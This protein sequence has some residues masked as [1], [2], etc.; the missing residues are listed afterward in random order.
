MGAK[1]RVSADIGG[2]F[3]DLVLQNAETG[4]TSTGKML[5]TREN[6]AR[7]VLDGLRTFL[8]E[9]AAARFLIHGTTVG[10]NAVLERRGAR[11][12][13]VTTRGFRDVYAIAGNDRRDIFSIHYRKPRPLI[14]RGDVF[15]VRERLNA[16]GSAAIP[17]V[18]EDLD[19]VAAAV[20]AGRY[21][22]VAVCLLFAYLNPVHELAVERWLRERLPDVPITLSHRVSP[23]WREYART[24]TAVMNAY[25]APVVQRYLATLMEKVRADLGISRLHVMESNGGAMTAEA[26]REKPIQSLLSGAGRRHDRGARGE[27][28]DRTGESHL[29]RHGRDLVRREP[30]HRRRP[31]P[32]PRRRRSSLP[33]QMSIVD[34]HVIGA[35]GGSVAWLEG[36]HLRV[37]PRSAGS[38]PGPA[39]YGA[40]GAEPTVTDANLVLG[41][42]DP[43]RFAGGRIRLDARAARAA[44]ASI[45]RAL[46]LGTEEMAAGIVEIVNAKMADA[47]R[48]IT[49]RRGIDP[50]DFALFA[51]GGAGPMQAAALAEQ[52]DIGEV[53]VPVHPGTFSAWGM[54]QADVRHDLKQTWFA[55]WDEVD[56][57]EV[58]RAFQALEAEGRAW[59]ER[60]EVPD[61][62]MAFVRSADLRYRLQEYQLTCPLPAGPGRLDREAVR[63]L[64]DA[65]YQRQYG[66]G[67]RRRGWRSSTC[68][69]PRPASSTGRPS[70][71]RRWTAAGR[72]GRA[73]SSSAVGRYARPFS[74]ASASRPASPWPGPP[75][76]KSRPRPPSCLPAGGPGC[77]RAA[78]CRSP[79]GS[80]DVN[81][82]ASRAADPITTE[83]V[84]NFMSAVA[85]DMNAALYRSAFSSVIYE[86]RDSAVAL[87][88]RNGDMLGQSTGVPIFI[89]NMEV[90]IRLTIEKYGLDWFE[91]GDVVILNDPYLQGTHTTTS[92]PSAPCS[93]AGSSPA[94]PRPAP[95]GRTSGPSIRAPR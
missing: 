30:R 86:G 61:E 16:D 40:G 22:A 81:A 65:A 71:P 4:E 56:L 67:N 51:Y 15:T 17:P 34:L 27:P 37:G 73:P 44:V 75:S 92:P 36:G 42:I 94:S 7:G 64:F 41:R 45:G 85:E 3:T 91:P 66:H 14:G 2:T 95:T 80:P 35:G 53:V 29:H 93:T 54:L 78:T 90:C 89:G 50:R 31:P 79:A 69:S 58:E 38:E 19:A 48:T 84:R 83:V 28:R 33:V 5:S 49:I 18:L 52:L 47:I 59:L 9:D 26:A 6:P 87:L 11:V 12:A 24:S 20:R 13:L 25:V 68:A 21:E 10:I 74:P 70:R 77:P 39:C 32:R 82:S 76:S 46:G 88:D 1:Y 57:G 55:A 72:P 8:P 62:R 43:E 60:E 63:R 23:E